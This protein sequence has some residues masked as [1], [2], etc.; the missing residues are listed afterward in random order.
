MRRVEK[1]SS[2]LEIH[3]SLWLKCWCEYGHGK[4]ILMKS[5]T[6]KRFRSL[7][8]GEKTNLDTKLER[9]W[10]DCASILCRKKGDTG[11]IAL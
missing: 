9:T 4:A 8:S 7:E 10:L 1:E 5:Q 11:L 3:K 2:F 6:E